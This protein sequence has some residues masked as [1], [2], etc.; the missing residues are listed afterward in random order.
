MLKM[1]NRE[2]ML[3][4]WKEEAGKMRT[5]MQPCENKTENTGKD[6]GIAICPS[7]T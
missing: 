3:Q 4:N 6:S 5:Q 7:N 2:S 1:M